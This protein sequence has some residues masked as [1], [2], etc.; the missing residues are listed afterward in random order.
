MVRIAVLDDGIDQ[1][2][3]VVDFAC[4]MYRRE[5]K[6]FVADIAETIDFNSHGAI[7]VRIISDRCNRNVEI[8]SYRIK[9]HDGNGNVNDLIAAFRDAIR[10]KVDIIHMSVGSCEKG[11]CN[12]LKRLVN[13]AERKKV[14]V[15]A[16]TDNGGELTYP[17]SFKNVIGVRHDIRGIGN[18]L[19]FI[20]Y[21]EQGVD[22]EV[23]SPKELTCTDDH[24]EKL[25]F[26][27]SYAAAVVTGIIA[28]MIE[29]DNGI[30]MEQVKKILR[31]K[32][33]K[34]YNTK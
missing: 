28:E 31:E 30:T 17:A 34:I 6:E 5:K 15:V 26:C 24:I 10:K 11:D 1:K 16:A 13:K 2:N 3:L 12:R 33:Y 25:P 19:I 9:K 29:K 4:V 14:I 23:C 22:V 20:D 32:A 18:K 7:C 27:N 8:I 21:S